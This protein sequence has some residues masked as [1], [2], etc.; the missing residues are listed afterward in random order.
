MHVMTSYVHA[1]TPAEHVSAV[2]AAAQIVSQ[3]MPGWLSK[4]GPPRCSL[5]SPHQA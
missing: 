1:R 3:Q 4:A 2:K 5:P